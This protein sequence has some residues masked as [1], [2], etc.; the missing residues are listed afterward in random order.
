VTRSQGSLLY[1]IKQ[2]DAALRP[3]FADACAQQGLT[4]AQYTALTVLQRRPGI[5]SAE[6]ARR[7]FVRAQTMASTLDPLL[8]AGMV[9][10]EADP[11]HLRRQLLYVTER[12]TAIVDALSPRI[13]SLEAL[14]VSDLS[15]DERLLFADY[16]RRARTALHNDAP[17]A[18]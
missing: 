13:E 7:S 6:L 14:L 10:R 1:V 4:L 3:R 2:L 17:E 9:R 5:S 16:L 15:E 18:K 12:G 11:S 8:S